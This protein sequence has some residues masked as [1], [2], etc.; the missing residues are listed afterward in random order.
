[1]WGGNTDDNDDLSTKTGTYVTSSEST[2]H[3]RPNTHTS[4]NIELAVSST[5]N[6]HDFIPEDEFWIS[7]E[8]S[9]H[10]QRFYIDHMLVEQR[11]MKEGKEYEDAWGEADKVQKRE[12]A[13]A[14]H[15]KK[16]K[17]I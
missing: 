3:T 6:S 2:S 9:M 8:N 16:P 15:N 11:L 12:R 13:K 17:K 10:E 1:M 4:M 14:N 7:K 5:M